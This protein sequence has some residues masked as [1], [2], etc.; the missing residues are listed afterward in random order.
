MSFPEAWAERIAALEANQRALELRVQQLERQLMTT[1]AGT[2]KQPAFHTPEDVTC[3]ARGGD[4]VLTRYG[5]GGVALSYSSQALH[6]ATVFLEPQSQPNNLF[7]GLVDE[8]KLGPP[9]GTSC[10]AGHDRCTSL[11]SRDIERFP[12]SQDSPDP[13]QSGGTVYAQIQLAD[14]AVFNTLG[15][16]RAPGT[17]WE[18]LDSDLAEML[19]EASRFDLEITDGGLSCTIDKGRCVTIFSG[20]PHTSRMHLVIGIYGTG[21]VLVKY[22][23][24]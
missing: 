12:G 23:I 20:L 7:I 19:R 24:P 11:D 17:T 16:V 10:D 18:S 6:Y 13:P 4:I 22:M 21:S 3:E 2:E 15:K 1:S 14:I 9:A 8:S 5:G